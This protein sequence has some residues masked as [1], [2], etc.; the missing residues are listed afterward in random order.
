MPVRHIIGTEQVEDEVDILDADADEDFEEDSDSDSDYIPP[1]AADWLVEPLPS[2]RSPRKS[3]KS[4]Q[5][6]A[7]MGP[8]ESPVE[9]TSGNPDEMEF[10]LTERPSLP[11]LP[12]TLPQKVKEVLDL[13]VVQHGYLAGGEV[14]QIALNYIQNSMD[15][16]VLQLIEDVLALASENILPEVAS[17]VAQVIYNCW[18]NK[19]E[20]FMLGEVL[21]VQQKYDGNH[22]ISFLEHLGSRDVEALFT[23]TDW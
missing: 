9:N 21:S 6:G 4:V 8:D 11:T 12:E 13:V 3:R 18:I 2:R 10:D 17:T 15:P 1:D 16:V 14:Q 19:T 23:R 22:I 5:D 20:S 7:Q